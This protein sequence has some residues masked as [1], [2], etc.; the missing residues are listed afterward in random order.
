MGV[1][2]DKTACILPGTFLSLE[3][4]ELIALSD[5]L[6]HTTRTYECFIILGVF[7]LDGR[8][9][10]PSSS[11]VNYEVSNHNNDDRTYNI[12]PPTTPPLDMSQV[13]PRGEAC[14][15]QHNREEEHGWRCSHWLSFS[16]RLT[17]TPRRHSQ[18]RVAACPTILPR[19][20]GTY[21]TSP[22]I[23]L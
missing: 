9:S 6:S 12:I 15:A 22:A 3:Y 20:R 11:L 16:Q 4:E 7:P 10:I 13:Y 23:S 14:G 1:Q 5:K 2:I 21:G 8:T 19:R 18:A 17:S